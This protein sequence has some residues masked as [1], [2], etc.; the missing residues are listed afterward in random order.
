MICCCCCPSQVTPK[1][2]NFQPEN[3]PKQCWPNFLFLGFQATGNSSPSVSLLFVVFSTAFIYQHYQTDNTKN[4]RKNFSWPRN[5]K[6]KSSA[7]TVLEHFR[8]GNSRFFGIF[9][10]YHR[11]A[12][13]FLYIL[14]DIFNFQKSPC[15]ARKGPGSKKK[16]IFQF[17][18]ENVNIFDDFSKFL[19]I[20]NHSRK[21]DF[22]AKKK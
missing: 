16:R 7:S 9:E 14:K 8:A 21:F 15:K 3:G 12:H 18:I 17:L 13:V 4:N 1:T 10:Y 5:T 20:L 2:A 11:N 22:F 6:T 19:L